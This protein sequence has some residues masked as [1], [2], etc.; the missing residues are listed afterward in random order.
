MKTLRQAI[1]SI[2]V[3]KFDENGIDDEFGHSRDGK[4]LIQ[5][6]TEEFE[7]PVWDANDHEYVISAIYNR[8]SPFKMELWKAVDTETGEEFDPE[9]L[10][11]V[12]PD[13][14]D[15]AFDHVG[16]SSRDF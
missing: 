11:K 7:F 4:P 6:D 9:E 3:E 2:I 15:R 1:R 8:R 13:L 5:R 12:I 14:Q 10:E 16:R